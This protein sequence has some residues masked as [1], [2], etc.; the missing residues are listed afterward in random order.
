MTQW[1]PRFAV[2]VAIAFA[3][4]ALNGCASTGADGGAE[5]KREKSN[6][7]WDYPPGYVPFSA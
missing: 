3:L 6:D 4:G 1:L 7:G 2:I 5:P